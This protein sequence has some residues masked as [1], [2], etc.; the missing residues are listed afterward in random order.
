M[1]PDA[2]NA[3]ARVHNPDIMSSPATISM[4]PAHHDG[5]APNAAAVPASDG[6]PNN[7]TEPWS[8][9]RKPTTTRN[10]NNPYGTFM[11]AFENPAVRAMA[12]R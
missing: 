3:A 4:S 2:T 8:A 11:P 5:H 9:K 12:P 1:V 10:T 6:H 7:F